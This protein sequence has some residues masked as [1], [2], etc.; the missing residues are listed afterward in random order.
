ML[1]LLPL[2]LETIPKMMHARF[3]T[4]KA[5]IEAHTRS[6]EELAILLSGVNGLAAVVGCCRCGLWVVS[7]GLLL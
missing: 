3:E 7:C 1:P 2:L 6:L 4:V 5:A